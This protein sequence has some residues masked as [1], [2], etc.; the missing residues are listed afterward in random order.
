L[1]STRFRS[2]EPGG[3]VLGVFLSKDFGE[4]VVRHGAISMVLDRTSALIIF[5]LVGVFDSLSETFRERL[6]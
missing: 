2:E 5:C 6:W 1:E 3:E 4:V